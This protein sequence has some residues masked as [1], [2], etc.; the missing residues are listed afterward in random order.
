MTDSIVQ[1]L[2]RPIDTRDRLPEREVKVL[3]R[4]RYAKEWAPVTGTVVRALHKYSSG[5]VYWMAQ[6][7]VK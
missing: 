3:V 4:T 2:K 7:G 1:S 6:E 5:P